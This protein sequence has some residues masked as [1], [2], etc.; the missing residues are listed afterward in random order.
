MGKLKFWLLSLL[1]GLVF[2]LSWPA[3]GNQSYLIFFAW[4]PLLFLEKDLSKHLSR[5]RSLWIFGYSYFAFFVFNILTTW[6]IYYASDWGMAMAVI[7][8]SLFM[9]T[10]FW[11]FHLCK[12][13]IG[14]KQGYWGLIILWIGFEYLHLN[15][16]L[17]WTWLTMGN[18]F[19]ND[20]EW[21]QWYEYTGVL[22]G[23]LLILF[24]NLMLFRSLNS[25]L[26]KKS[27]PFSAAILAV[28]VLVVLFST[29]YS[30][31]HSYTQEGEAIEVVAIQPNID[32]YN[33]K[34]HGIPESEQIDRMVRLSLDQ[35]NDKTRV[36]LWPE[37]A[38][39]TPCWEHEFDYLYGVEE[40]RK[41]IR[42][43][44]DVRVITGLLSTRLILEEKDLS[45]TSK[46]FRHG[47]GWYDNYN[48]AIEV[49]KDQE[50]ELHHK[51]KLVLGVEKVPFLK[52][53][54]IMKRLSI[55]L[56]GS[57]GG[58]GEDG[59]P[60]VFFNNQDEQGIGPI[61]C[62]ESIYGEYVTEYVRK[63]AELLVIITND[64]WW[65][66]TPGYKQHLAYARLR[67]IETRRA[68]GRSANTGISGFINQRGDVF[69]TTDWWVVDS[70]SGALHFNDKI[71]FYVQYGDYIGRTVGFLAPLFLLLAFVKSRNKTEQ[72][73][74][75]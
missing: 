36:I 12:K 28:I 15:W 71:T 16:E 32:P 2:A 58:Y 75:I 63:G 45:P 3:I 18:V 55:N 49:E 52:H 25:F 57:S 27:R 7:C 64:G 5:W 33:E 46:K 34:F 72:R 43:Y 38:F 69:N 13:W 41:I 61:I 35:T 62:Y 47:V 29:S 8:N 48:T 9:A 39:P 24:V 74:S 17:S 10:T 1:S 30:T 11:L 42:E 60:T 59:S 54:P 14:E 53:F 73:L 68:I 66:D 51:S 6:W 21:I 56:G 23:S 20:P 67:A 31:Y 37:T 26:A 40:I 65:D 22:G 19:A 50:V 4:I 44:P 70:V